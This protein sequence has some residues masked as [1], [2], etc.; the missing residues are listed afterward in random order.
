MPTSITSSGI[1][2]DDA[3]TLTTGVVPTA[4]IANGAVTPVKLSQP[5]TLATSVA[6][7]SGTAIDFTGIPSWA[8]RVTVLIAGIS[9]NG[10]SSMQVQLGTSG[11][12]ETSS[13]VCMNSVIINSAA[14]ASAATSGFV[15]N[16]CTA[17]ETYSG[18]AIISLVSSNAWTFQSM[19]SRVDASAI[20]HTVGSKSLS[21]TLDRVRITTVNGTDTFD[22]GTINISY[23][24]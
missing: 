2:F 6:S 15:T 11:G 14:L 13:Y 7:T 1:T 4:N 19:M 10:S 5:F 8:R 17:S 16:G 12:F 3:T 22:A 24:G 23:E 9:T 18:S 20:A 21:G